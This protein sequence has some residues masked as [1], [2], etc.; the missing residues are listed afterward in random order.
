MAENWI[1]EQTIDLSH[2]RAEHLGAQPDLLMLPGDNKAHTWR[3]VCLRD[4]AAAT[5]SGL[6]VVGYFLRQDGSTVAVPGTVSGNVCSVTLAQACY[7]YPGNIRA[8]IRCTETASGT[9]IT[10]AERVFTV[11]RSIDSGDI[12]D[13]GSAVPSLEDLLAQIAA[14]ETATAAAQAAVASAATLEGRISALE[15][16]KAEKD[17]V[18]YLV[19][20]VQEIGVMAS[21][22][23]RYDGAQSLTAAQK[24]IAC[25]NIGAAAVTIENHTL[26]I[27]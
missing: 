5:L 25:G 9:R 21:N 26:V 15:T 2:P 19:V 14:M 12:I 20:D 22:A 18:D 17:L 10:L 4:G 13:P 11:R 6:T 27:S 7:A 1:L 24:A 3:V 8:A 23:V 16:D